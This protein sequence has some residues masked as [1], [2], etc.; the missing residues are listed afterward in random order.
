VL[1][2]LADIEK[3]DIPPHLRPQFKTVLQWDPS[4]R[5]AAARMPRVLAV[6]MYEAAFGQEGVVMWLRSL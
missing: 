1:L 5:Y 3:A 2:N 4:H 6:E